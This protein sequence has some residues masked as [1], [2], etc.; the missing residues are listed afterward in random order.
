MAAY[1]GSLFHFIVAGRTAAGRQLGAPAPELNRFDLFHGHVFVASA[2]RTT[3]G[4][5]TEQQ[6]K[7]NTT[8]NGL[9]QQS[10]HTHIKRPGVSVPATAAQHTHSGKQGRLPEVGILVSLAKGQALRQAHTA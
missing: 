5:G 1:A 10:Q 6:E 9:A 8:H 2:N 4:S 7:V 3:N